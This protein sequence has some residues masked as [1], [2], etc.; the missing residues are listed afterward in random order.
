[1][2][3]IDQPRTQTQTIMNENDNKHLKLYLT[4]IIHMQV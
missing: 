4:L 1:M 2:S 3:E